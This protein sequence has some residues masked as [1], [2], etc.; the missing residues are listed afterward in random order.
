MHKQL[1][2]DFLIP[3]KEISIGFAR[4]F[5]YYHLN[6]IEAFAFYVELCIKKIAN[7]NNLEH[8]LVVI[9]TLKNYLPNFYHKMM[10]LEQTLSLLHNKISIG[11]FLKNKVMNQKLNQ[12]LEQVFGITGLYNCRKVE[13]EVAR[14]ALPNLSVFKSKHNNFCFQSTRE[15]IDELIQTRLLPI[16]R[17]EISE[18]WIIFYPTLIPEPFVIYA[19]LNK[20][21]IVTVISMRPNQT[22]FY[23]TLGQLHSLLQEQLSKQNRLFILLGAQGERSGEADAGLQCLTLCQ[24]LQKETHL[25]YLIDIMSIESVTSAIK[26]QIISPK[27]FKPTIQLTDQNNFSIQEIVDNHTFFIANIDHLN[28]SLLFPEVANNSKFSALYNEIKNKKH[29]KAELFLVA[30]GK[31][32]F[33]YFCKIVALAKKHN[34]L[35]ALNDD[36][37]TALSIANKY[38]K[39]DRA[40]YLKTQGAKVENAE[41]RLEHTVNLILE[42]YKYYSDVRKLV[43]TL[44]Q[45]LNATRITARFDL[46]IYQKLIAE[47][48][49][50]N[51]QIKVT[52]DNYGVYLYFCCSYA[53]ALFKA[54]DYLVESAQVKSNEN[55]NSNT[56]EISEQVQNKKMLSIYADR[57][58]KKLTECEAFLANLDSTFK[59]DVLFLD[60]FSATRAQISSNLEKLNLKISP[61]FTSAKK[62]ANQNQDLIEHF[63]ADKTLFIADIDIVNRFI[64]AHLLSLISTENTTKTMIVADSVQPDSCF[65]AL[66]FSSKHENKIKLHLIILLPEDRTA[67]LEFTKLLAYCLKQRKIDYEISLC[68]TKQTPSLLLPK[69]CQATATFFAKIDPLYFFKLLTYVPELVTG[70]SL[71]TLKLKIN[72]KLITENFKFSLLDQRLIVPINFNDASADQQQ[73]LTALQDKTKLKELL[74]AGLK[75]NISNEKFEILV[76]LAKKFN[77]IDFK[78]GATACSLLQL[79]LSKHKYAKAAILIRAGANCDF[80]DANQKSVKQYLK[81]S[82]T[83]E[84]IQKKLPEELET[85]FSIEITKY[86]QA[87]LEKQKINLS[88]QPKILETKHLRLTTQFNPK[89][90]D[91]T[92]IVDNSFTQLLEELKINTDPDLEQDDDE[93]Q[94]QNLVNN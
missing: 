69:I 3:K 41:D 22:A 2:V 75:D 73:F 42:Q 79:T 67:N 33:D 40:N 74:I 8:F 35:N 60:Y 12:A 70:Q 20:E 5:F 91:S 52:S 94:Q 25:N 63:V 36:C 65:V 6:F 56:T 83:D 58:V 86:T 48:E 68:E 47:L 15:A 14:L 17:N 61:E 27:F 50:L 37:L 85:K 1:T 92:E 78:I 13:L 30:R 16:A 84:I 46:P 90:K 18:Q 55:S 51:T 66:A 39:Q 49:K 7:D 87:Y 64:D 31:K 89:V 29:L 82:L 10:R 4:I 77:L 59:I 72:G 32:S 11:L 44:H 71:L 23:Y 57:I 28:F 88:Q 38:K 43:T 54:I 34:V 21:L 26:E 80:I 81:D 24:T 9:N 19:A 45:N 53:Q 93:Q 62:L 76:A